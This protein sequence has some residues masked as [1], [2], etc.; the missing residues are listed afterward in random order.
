MN[1]LLE[2]ADALEIGRVFTQVADNIDEAAQLR[3]VERRQRRR[4]QAERIADAMI[5]KMLEEEYK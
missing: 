3:R 5:R 1:D 2:F 4:E